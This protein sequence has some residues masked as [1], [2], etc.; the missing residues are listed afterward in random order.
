[1]YDLLMV[2]IG[3]SFLAMCLFIFLAIIS[4]INKKSSKS[5]NMIKF[6]GFSLAAIFFFGFVSELFEEDTP[7]S[8]KKTETSAPVVAK[9]TEEEKSIR[10]AKEAETKAKEEAENAKAKE[11]QA[12]ADADAKLKAE[13]E[14][15]KIAEEK[16]VAEVKFYKEELSP[17]MQ[18]TL[19]EYVAIWEQLWVATFN[20]VSNGSV[21]V[22]NAYSNMKA[23]DT[24]YRALST[25]IDNIEK[26]S[27][28]KKNQKELKTFKSKLN[29]AVMYRRMAS[30]EAADMFDA[31]TFRPSEFED[32]KRIV[33][34]SDID[35]M[36][37]ALSMTV[38]ED[39]LGL[40]GE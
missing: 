22:Y 28:S 37:A 26:G 16:R 15:V 33:N 8:K 14:K 7:V 6:A 38:I 32:V 34:S 31:G 18:T 24:Q 11:E 29:S 21:D 13:A 27:L 36:Q 10:V 35:M 19:K 3:A 12:K 2:L 23:I 4:W 17:Q 5:K 39:N 40:L 25:K 1:M 9:E 20:G 30:D